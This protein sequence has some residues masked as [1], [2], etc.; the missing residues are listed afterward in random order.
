MSLDI[1]R[2]L[3]FLR[4]VE[5]VHRDIRAVNILITLNET[6]KLADFIIL[7]RLTAPALIQEIAEERIPYKDTNNN[8]VEIVDKVC[9]KMYRE[10]L[11][12]NSQMPEEF[13]QL[14]FEAVHQDPYFRPDITK[15]FEVLRNCVKDY[16]K[17]PSTSLIPTPKRAYSIDQDAHALPSNLPDFKSFTY[18]TLTDA[19]KQH[20]LCD[21]KGKLIGDTV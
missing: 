21:R 8:T 12:E 4:T 5:I 9:N 15:I 20:K 2:G 14:Q 10:L 17:R 19:E 13:K 1:A 3:N 7:S 16:S 11:S 6:A 18:M